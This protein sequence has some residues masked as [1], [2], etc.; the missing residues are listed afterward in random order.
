M[1]TNIINVGN[2]KGIIIPAKLLKLH[3]LKDKVRLAIEDNKMIIQ[4][5]E[6]N[7]RANWEE[8]FK[9][10]ATTYDDSEL[11]PDVFEEEDFDDWTW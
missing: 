1:E 8:Q 2:S 9:N 10:N 7:P 6:N 4:S 5:I 3:G 11:I